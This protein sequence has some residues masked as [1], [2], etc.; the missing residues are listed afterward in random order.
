VSTATDA[1]VDGNRSLWVG[2]HVAAFL[3]G[4]LTIFL[5]FHIETTSH[6][7]DAAI[8]LGAVLIGA[9]AGNFVGTGVGT[10]LKLQHPERVIMT[11][12]ATAAVMC[13]LTAILFTIPFAVIG[14]FVS[15][16]T[17]SL[18]KIA[19]DAVIQRDVP[20]SQRSS[21]FARSETF[22]Q[23]AWVLGAA[24]AVL[25]PSDN[26]S[27]GFW[28]AAA[29]VGGI[30]VLVLLRNRAMKRAAAATKRRWDTQPGIAPGGA[31]K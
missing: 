2:L 13:F 30:T 28:I 25:L 24:I 17:N 20:E 9:G 7:A 10:R 16:A 19:L 6:G 15:S 26:G 31:A 12:N 23:L 27:L 8:A 11:C 22:L 18:A 3:S 4:F 14:M 5:A 29:V 1:L 21:A